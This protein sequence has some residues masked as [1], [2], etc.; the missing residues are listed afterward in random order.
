MGLNI[1]N[2]RYIGN[3]SKLLKFI[4]ETIEKENIQFNTFGDVFAGTGVVAEYFLNKGKDIYVNDLLFSNYVV[5]KALLDNCE[6]QK[7]K[8]KKIIDTYNEIDSEKLEDNYFSDN[9]SGNYYHYYDAK[10]I[11]YIREDIEQKY[12]NKEINSREYYILVVCLLYSMDKISNT[13]GH[14]ESFLNR[15]PEYKNLKISYMNIKKYQAKSYIYNED[16]NQ[17]VRRINVD[18]MYVDPPYNARQYANFYHLLENV[19]HW[20][21]PKVYNKAKKMERK[22]IMSNYCRSNAKAVFQDLIENISAKYIIVSY[23]NTYKAKSTSS[24]NSITYED[25]MEI[26]TKKGQVKVY[27]T[28]YRYFNS[29]KTNLDKHKERLFICKVNNKEK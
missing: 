7:K 4:D 10:K 20:E 9:F 11:G 12:L 29:G 8:I 5:Y 28:D 15:E 6:Y 24:I 1:E 3:K 23:N 14:Y 17:L 2:R 21:K 26:L 18:V 19:A 16:A 27:E 13:V 22:N 25:M